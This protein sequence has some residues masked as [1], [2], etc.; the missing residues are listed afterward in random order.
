MS[1][2]IDI[3]TLLIACAG[4]VPVMEG[5]PRRQAERLQ[6]LALRRS[7]LVDAQVSAATNLVDQSVESHPG[8]CSWLCNAVV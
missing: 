1:A 6:H 3:L 7:E 4:C 8:N 5:G 2:R